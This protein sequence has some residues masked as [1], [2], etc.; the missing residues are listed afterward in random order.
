MHVEQQHMGVAGQAQ[1]ACT[2]HRRLVQGHRLTHVGQLRF[3]HA[4][5]LLGGGQK[6][7]VVHWQVQVDRRLDHQQRLT[8]VVTVH[9]AAQHFVALHQ[10]L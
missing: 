2:Q 1:Q 3:K 5:L 9:R 10:H 8:F 4:Q 7:Q 6:A